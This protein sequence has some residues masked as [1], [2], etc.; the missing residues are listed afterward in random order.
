M[1]TP[2]PSDAPRPLRTFL[3]IS[4]FQALAM[5]RRG[6]FYSY[7]AIYLRAFLH[8][9]VTETTLF[10]TLPM[11]LNV[12]FQ[13]F[14]WGR[15]SDRYQ[16]RRTLIMMGEVLAGFGTLVVWYAHTLAAT[17][18]IAG[19]VVILG[20]SVV[21][22]FWSMSNVGWSAL[23]SDLYP[24]AERNAVQ[25]RLASIGGLGRIAGVWI[26]GVLYDGLGHLYPGWGFHQGALFCVAAGVMFL[27][28]FP[29]LWVPEGG[30]SATDAPEDPGVRHPAAGQRVFVV[31]LIAM[32]LIN[33][34]RNS[35]ALILSPYLVLESGFALSS[36]TV[37][38]IVNMQ[39]GAIMLTGLLMG[40]LS[41]HLGDRRTLCIGAVAAI[42]GLLFLALAD[43]LW[44][45]YLA[46]FL[47]GVAEA[48]VFTSS[49]AIASILI[50]P[51]ERG[52]LFGWFN[53]TFFLSW[54]LAATGIAG[55]II[56]AMLHLGYPEVLAYRMAF[57]SALILTGIGL[58]MLGV[59][60]YM[61]M[62]ARETGPAPDAHPARG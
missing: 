45:L 24:E 31:F 25:G 34:G 51:R 58:G 14:V 28:I 12:L 27:S 20:L 26:G 21:E 23:I 32:V 19:Y 18:L 38:Y 4:S 13:T 2:L 6:L 9:S 5:F 59:L 53:A 39:S 29:M 41:R 54:G 42:L 43:R 11:I 10:A 36:M 52:R 49:Y 56:D 50:P 61:V 16:V 15:L 44:M 22:I 57:G 30:V 8:L 55:P 7:L 60:F 37:S 48:M 40:L 62:P 47:R 33:F 17:P 46:N 3:G 35:V 1:H